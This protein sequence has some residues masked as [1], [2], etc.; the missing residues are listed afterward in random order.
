MSYG[1][2]GV[3]ASTDELGSRVAEGQLDGLLTG[4]AEDLGE[5]LNRRTIKIYLDGI[6][7]DDYAHVANAVWMLLRATS[8]SYA[9]EPDDETQPAELDKA[10]DSYSDVSYEHGALRGTEQNLRGRP[11]LI[12]CQDHVESQTG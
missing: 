3:V 7:P 11:G 12:A 1:P 9:V 2:E 8:H 6:E 10:W 4:P 5:A